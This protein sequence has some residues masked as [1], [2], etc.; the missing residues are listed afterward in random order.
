MTQIER[1]YYRGET[2]MTEDDVSKKIPHDL[3][4]RRYPLLCFDV[5]LSSTEGA[6]SQNRVRSQLLHTR[7]R[8]YAFFQVTH[9]TSSFI[10]SLGKRTYA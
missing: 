6:A 7:P 2:Q 5:L 9:T 1:K 8:R 10:Y 4:P 3:Y